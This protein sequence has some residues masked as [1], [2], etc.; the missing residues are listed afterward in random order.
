MQPHEPDVIPPGYQ[1]HVITDVIRHDDSLTIRYSGRTFGGIILAEL[2]QG[3][4]DHV[5]PGTVV[6][7]RYHTEETGGA[8]IVAHMLMPNP[9]DEGW[10][11]LYEDM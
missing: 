3:V 7:V 1:R 10:A 6:I 4:A 5:V 9:F 2:P 11:E 8:G